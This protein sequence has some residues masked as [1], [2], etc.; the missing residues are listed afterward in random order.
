MANRDIIVIGGSTGSG[1][2]CIESFPS[3]RAI[4]QQ[5][6]LSRLT[7]P[8]QSPGYLAHMLAGTS[9]LKVVEAIA[10]ADQMPLAALE[11]V[12]AHR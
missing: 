10:K 2:C 8:S 7:S 11:V 12:D 1:R 6:S 5:A 3:F 4:C 9:S